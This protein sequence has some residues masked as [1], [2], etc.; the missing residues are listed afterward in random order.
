MVRGKGGQGFC[1]TGDI[2]GRG[3]DLNHLVHLNRYLQPEC[4]KVASD[5]PR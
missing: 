5:T 3:C 4:C 2:R 1:T